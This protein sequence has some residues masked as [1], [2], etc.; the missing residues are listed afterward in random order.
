M[1]RSSRAVLVG[2]TTVVWGCGSFVVQGTRGP[3]VDGGRAAD[4]LPQDDAPADESAPARDVAPAADAPRVPLGNICD[5]ALPAPVVG[6]LTV[7]PPERTEATSSLVTDNPILRDAR[8]VRWYRVSV[9]PEVHFEARTEAGEGGFPALVGG[10]TRCAA[11]AWVARARD[12]SGRGVLAWPNAGDAP[13]DLYFAVTAPGPQ[14]RAATLT[15]SARPI[16]ANGFCATPTVVS[17]RSSLAAEDLRA[18]GEPAGHCFPPTP[19]IA[20]GAALHYRAHV[21]AGETLFA[22]RRADAAGLS[23][24]V[25]YVHVREQCG[26]GACLAPSQWG[27][28]GWHRIATAW[29]NDGPSRD[30]IVT[31]QGLANLDEF[32][33]TT[34]FRVAPAAPNTRC[35][36]AAPLAPD[37]PQE[38][39]VAS[40]PR[41]A[42][43]CVSPET[44]QAA[45]YTVDVPARATLEVTAL[46]LEGV[47]DEARVVLFAGCARPA[48]LPQGDSGARPDAAATFVN[49]AE[50]TAVTVA[51]TGIAAHG[52]AP[53]LARVTARV[54]P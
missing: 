25:G 14:T 51:V 33:A 6:R 8:Y 32:A 7:A 40:A 22:S 38:V 50:A 39:N 16:A 41:T 10:F 48:C 11:E 15:L 24:F 43:P 30:V 23:R 18:A 31:V 12:E 35:E 52:R 26:D 4:A 36:A 21:R 44:R 53:F 45:F 5:D 3:D 2:F 46:P 54:R 37:A 13:R 49:G 17:D 34:T 27:L 29:T 1:R 47:S 42:V 28:D 19:V 9:P 20:Q